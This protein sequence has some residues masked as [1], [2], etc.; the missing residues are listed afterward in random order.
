MAQILQK[1]LCNYK[2]WIRD[3]LNIFLFH[4]NDTDRMAQMYWSLYHNITFDAVLFQIC[5]IW[6]IVSELESN[7]FLFISIY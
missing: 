4:N 7:W 3:L 1:V 2:K 6:T 5:N